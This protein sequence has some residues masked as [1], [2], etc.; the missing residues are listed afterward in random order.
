MKKR[1]VFQFKL[2]TVRRSLGRQVRHSSYDMH[3]SRNR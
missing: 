3:E 1:I 2:L